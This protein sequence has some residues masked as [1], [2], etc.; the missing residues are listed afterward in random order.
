MGVVVDTVIFVETNFTL[1]AQS[2]EVGGSSGPSKTTLP[3]GTN[4]KGAAQFLP[5]GSS[6]EDSTLREC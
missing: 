4:R 6:Q 3:Q 5:Y 2:R 1:M